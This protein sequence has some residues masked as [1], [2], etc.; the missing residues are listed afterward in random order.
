MSAPFNRLAF[1]AVAGVLA[2]PAQAGRVML[3]SYNGGGNLADASADDTVSVSRAGGYAAAHQYGGG[4]GVMASAISN[5]INMQAQAMAS[6]VRTFTVSCP[7]DDLASIQCGLDFTMLVSGS[8]S[9][10]HT[11]DAGNPVMHG[12]AQAGYSMNWVVSG[13]GFSVSGGG[14]VSEFAYDN[15]KREKF[16]TGQPFSSHQLLYVDNGSQVTISLSASAG[17]FTDNSGTGTASAVADFEHT[18]RWGGLL[19]AYDAD[20]HALDLSRVSLMGS[21]GYDYVHAAP[22]NPFVPGIPEPG[23]WA[24]LLSGLAVVAVRRRRD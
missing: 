1:L 19:G 7:L 9:V 11:A 12:S 13:A 15:G 22:P 4:V 17:A 16:E 18:L 6:S 20:G 23:T 2:G 14:S 3:F 21:D 8:T 5:A 10:S 24:L